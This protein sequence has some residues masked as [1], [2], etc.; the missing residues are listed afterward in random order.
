M[1][2][3]NNTFG[4]IT[5]YNMKFSLLF[6][7]LQTC[8]EITH[9]LFGRP[10]SDGGSDF[11]EYIFPNSRGGELSSGE[12]EGD[13]DGSSSQCPNEEHIVAVSQGEIIPI[14]GEFI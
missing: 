2:L 6:S 1:L 10:A 4:K 7:L 8:E 12:R 9:K 13:I 14:P 5:S 3:E 11:M